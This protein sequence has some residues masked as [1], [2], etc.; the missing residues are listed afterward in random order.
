MADRPAIPARKCAVTCGQL[1]PSNQLNWNM[2]GS[3]PLHVTEHASQI[4]QFL[5]TGGVKVQATP[6]DRGYAQ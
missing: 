3:I 6:G 1:T 4:L 5:T 2:V